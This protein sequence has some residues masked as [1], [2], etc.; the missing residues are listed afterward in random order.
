MYD[1]NGGGCK[2]YSFVLPMTHTQAQPLPLS[3]MML[4][5]LYV[6]SVKYIG[7]IFLHLPLALLLIVRYL[8]LLYIMVCCDYDK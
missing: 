6:S 8:I 7:V 3:A 5:R 2:G 4:L 1:G